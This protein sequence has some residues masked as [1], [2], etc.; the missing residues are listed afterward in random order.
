MKNFAGLLLVGYVLFNSF[1]AEAQTYAES[2]LIFSRT[3][4]GGSARIQALGGTQVS[5]GG[6]YSSAYSNPAG[7]GMYNRSE[8]TITPGYNSANTSS[9]YLGMGT[10][11]TQSKLIIPGLSFVFHSDKSKGALVSGTFGITFNRINDFNRTFE[12]GAVNPNNSI[13]DYFVGDAN[14]SNFSGGGSL[15]P[16]NG[17]PSQLFDKGGDLYNTPTELAWDNYLINTVS[18]AD[19]T[20]YTTDFTGIPTQHE[21]VQLSG[22]QNQWSFSY[23]INLSDK[24]F[25]G[26]GIGVTS[27]NYTSKKT[28]TETFPQDSLLSSLTLVENL[29]TKGSGF[30]ATLGAIY[31]PMDIFQ[32]GVSVATPTA[33]ILSDTYNANMATDWVKFPF[34]AANLP[35]KPVATDDVFTDYYLTTPWRVSGGATFF[36]Q[37]HGFVSADIEYLN[38]SSNRYSTSTTGVSFTG[39]NSD[40]KGL[41]HSV[42]NYRLGAEYRRN[43]FRFRAGYSYMPDPYKSLQNNVYNDIQS[44]SAGVGYRA[45]KFFVDLT[46]VFTQ[47]NTTYRPYTNSPIVS[48]QNKNTLIMATVGFPF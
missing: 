30:N 13:I 36:I 25:L 1:T 24:F 9:D 42:L 19:Q 4:P 48:N 2:A 21:K 29:R 40:I 47:G 26:G 5:L 45:S 11:S 22:A 33:Y 28:Y 34:G 3:R 16:R 38:Y 17:T 10:G 12:Y 23:G 35:P 37:K 32:F 14:F 6:D 31:K 15:T 18:A 46:G 20:H 8:V 43:A 27:I 41:Y 7:L 39:D 44:F